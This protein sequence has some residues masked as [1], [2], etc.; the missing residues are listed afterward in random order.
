MQSEPTFRR[1]DLSTERI[2]M[3]NDQVAE[4]TQEKTRDAEMYRSIIAKSKYRLVGNRPERQL[5]LNQTA[6]AFS[7][8]T[9][10]INFE[11]N[12]Y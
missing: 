1:L 4:L 11:S 5:E 10:I 2:R 9:P 12:N 8:K 6:Q 7:A 3:L